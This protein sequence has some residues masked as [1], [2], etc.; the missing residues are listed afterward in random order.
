MALDDPL[1]MAG[2]ELSGDALT[3][4]VSKVDREHTVASATGRELLRPRL[5]ISSRRLRPAARHVAVARVRPED[6]GHRRGRRP[7][8]GRT[9]RAKGRGAAVRAAA[10]AA[11]WARAVVFSPFG[12]EDVFPSQLPEELPWQF[13]YDRPADE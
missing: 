11:R 10:A 12:A 7:G 2:Y 13:G 5:W 3:G 8:H 4:T 1:V 6:H 9:D